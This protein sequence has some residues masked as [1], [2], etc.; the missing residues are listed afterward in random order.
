M[1][2]INN[3]STYNIKS[4]VCKVDRWIPDRNIGTTI[5]ASTFQSTHT[6]DGTTKVFAIPYDIARSNSLTVTVGGVTTLTQTTR[7]LN[8]GTEL[9]IGDSSTVSAGDTADATNTLTNT[10]PFTYQ[11]EF[12]TNTTA[13]ST[14]TLCDN[15]NTKSSVNL[16][17]LQ[18]SFNTAPVNGSAIVITLKKT[19][20]GKNLTTKFDDGAGD[21]TTFDGDGTVFTNDLVTFD[22]KTEQSTQ[23]MMQRSSITDR[24]TH[25]SKQRKLLR[26]A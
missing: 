7:N 19:T 17:Q 8:A 22:R 4:L 25:I 20:F 10:E 11:T 26:T 9:S 18:L 3:E 16:T 1:Y 21:E 13:D 24:I 23:V 2:K 5:D 12:M 6:G 14:D 15:S